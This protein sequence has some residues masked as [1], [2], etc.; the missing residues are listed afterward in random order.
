M[1]HVSLAI[2]S[3]SEPPPALWPVS[4]GGHNSLI[5]SDLLAGRRNI[6]LVRSHSVTSAFLSLSAAGKRAIVTHS[7]TTSMAGPCACAWLMAPPRVEAVSPRIF[8]REGY[9]W[10]PYPTRRPVHV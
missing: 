3:T 9:S 4:W 7:T 5:A 6:S 10:E 1:Q 2:L 8:S